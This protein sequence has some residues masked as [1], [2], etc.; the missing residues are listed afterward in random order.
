MYANQIESWKLIMII[1]TCTQSKYKNNQLNMQFTLTSQNIKYLHS[2]LNNI[3]KKLSF[4]HQ[5]HILAVFESES[6]KHRS[7]EVALAMLTINTN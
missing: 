6:R 7:T 4:Y 2:S 5:L 1:H 3:K